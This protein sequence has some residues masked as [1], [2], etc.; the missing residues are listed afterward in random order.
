MISLRSSGAIK[1]RAPG[2]K[3]GMWTVPSF[4]VGRTVSW[5]LLRSPI[6]TLGTITFHF[7][8]PCILGCGQQP[9]FVSIRSILNLMWAAWTLDLT[10]CCPACPTGNKQYGTVWPGCLPV[11]SRA[12]CHTGNFQPLWKPYAR[13][14]SFQTASHESV[15]NSAVNSV[16]SSLYFL[17]G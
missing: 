16:Q 4:H 10:G 13:V 6:N 14:T 5:P 3:G 8:S 2:G 12:C 11:V 15:W 7:L 1:F 17:G 9:F